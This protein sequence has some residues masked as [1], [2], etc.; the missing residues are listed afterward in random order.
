M[1]ELSN[2]KTLHVET[3]NCDDGSVLTIL[4]D[5]ITA[6]GCLINT[7]AFYLID[8]QALISPPPLTEQLFESISAIYLRE[9]H[10]HLRVPDH[11]FS[12]R[13]LAIIRESVRQMVREELGK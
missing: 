9:T 13:S 10:R 12:I 4:V 1:T 6:A 8:K 3:L 5:R 11:I 7:G 2:D